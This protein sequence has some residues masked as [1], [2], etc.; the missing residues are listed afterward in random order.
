MTVLNGPKFRFYCVV[1]L[2]L[3]AHADGAAKPLQP[4]NGMNLNAQELLSI[5]SVDLPRIAFFP[6][7]RYL[8]LTG[9][10]SGSDAADEPI[11]LAIVYD[12]EA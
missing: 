12:L 6:G 7:S 9:A 11:G 1:S 10:E 2:S 8:A 4:N 3:L 5:S